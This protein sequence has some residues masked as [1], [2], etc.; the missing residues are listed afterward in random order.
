MFLLD[1]RGGI[2]IGK[3]RLNLRLR[4]HLLAYSRH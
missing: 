3:Q 4:K 2:E 1:D